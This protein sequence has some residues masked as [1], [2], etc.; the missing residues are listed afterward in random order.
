MADYC[1]LDDLFNHNSLMNPYFIGLKLLPKTKNHHE[2]NGWFAFTGIH[3]NGKHEII[4]D[5][6]CG[7]NN[8]Y[9]DTI[10]YRLF[11]FCQKIG[12]QT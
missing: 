8:Q 7:S 4:A 10:K 1:S 3:R 9:Y 12:V 11:I 6:W 2:I 5:V